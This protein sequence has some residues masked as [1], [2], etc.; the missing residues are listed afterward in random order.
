MYRVGASLPLLLI[1]FVLV[2]HNEAKRSVEI[3]GN[4]YRAMH[5]SALQGRLPD[6]RVAEF[7]AGAQ[8]DEK[9]KRLH[10]RGML[11]EWTVTS[12]TDAFDAFVGWTSC[13]VDSKTLSASDVA[14]FIAE[15]TVQIKVADVYAALQSAVEQFNS[16]QQ[17]KPY[18]LVLPS[19]GAQ[20]IAESE[21]FAKIAFAQLDPPPRDVLFSVEIAH[22]VHPTINRENGDAVD[23]LMFQSSL[24]AK[25]LATAVDE[26]LH[27]YPDDFVESSS[28]LHIIAPYATHAMRQLR[29]FHLHASA[30]DTIKSAAEILGSTSLAGSDEDFGSILQKCFSLSVSDASNA[31]PPPL[32]LADTFLVY[33][34][35]K[36][37]DVDSPLFAVYEFRVAGFSLQNLRLT[38]SSSFR[39]VVESHSI[40]QD[41]RFLVPDTIADWQKLSPSTAILARIWAERGTSRNYGAWLVPREAKDHVAQMGL[42]RVAVSLG[43]ANILPLPGDES[44]TEKYA[45]RSKKSATGKQPEYMTVL[46]PSATDEVRLHPSDLA[47]CGVRFTEEFNAKDFDKFLLDFFA[48]P[49]KD[50][51]FDFEHGRELAIRPRCGAT[52]N[53]KDRPRKAVVFDFDGTL[54]V[55][56]DLNIRLEGR[57]TAFGKPVS[58]YIWDDLFGGETRVASMARHL[59]ALKQQGWSIFLLTHHDNLADN[60]MILSTLKLRKYF[61]MLY[62][63]ETS[64]RYSCN[65]ITDKNAPT[66]S[67]ALRYLNPVDLVHS[68]FVDDDGVSN[69]P[70]AQFT[71][72]K[73]VLVDRGVQDDDWKTLFRAIGA[74]LPESKLCF[75]FCL[76]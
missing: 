70:L 9:R 59:R 69:I 57:E 46:E 3:D 10:I 44:P 29:G 27:Q 22:A 50:K 51:Y 24:S 38:A 65:V 19:A 56:G 74:K 30:G 43:L 20:P 33:Y 55:N 37:T 48:Y 52:I 13:V 66:K 68:A 34:D 1:L 60:N 28:S 7:R 75:F 40:G 76:F 15:H 36:Y 47:V 71:G 18:I 23:F 26:Q 32:D 63:I 25:K 72:Y 61:T 49:G 67:G 73:T 6:E 2:V 64:A 5:I 8:R 54:T 53:E 12:S 17:K 58:Q 41:P 39:E 45:E 21:W 42:R 62:G 14:H 4:Y 31:P 16:R 11:S 35:Y